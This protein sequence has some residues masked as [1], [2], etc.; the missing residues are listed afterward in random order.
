MLE[1]WR[2]G[3]VGGRGRRRR[4]REA[5]GDHGGK[6]RGGGGRGGGLAAATEEKV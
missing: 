5:R 6:G 3:A 1:P 4:G 2:G